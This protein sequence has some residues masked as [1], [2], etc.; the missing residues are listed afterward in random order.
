M[1]RFL[2]FTIL[3]GDKSFRI[4]TPDPTPQTNLCIEPG[5]SM[6]GP[7]RPERA[8]ASLAPPRYEPPSAAWEG[9]PA[10]A[11][12]LSRR[13]DRCVTTQFRLRRFCARPLRCAGGPAASVASLTR[14]QPSASAQGSLRAAAK[15]AGD[16]VLDSEGW[17]LWVIGLCL[18]LPS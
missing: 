7:G 2:K 10:T 4:R 3:N 9:C 15:G 14:F 17:A 1:S 8:G 5:G 13:S 11:G 6:K 12:R 18:P 16:A